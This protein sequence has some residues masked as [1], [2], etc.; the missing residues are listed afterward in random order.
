FL[1]LAVTLPAKGTEVS[2]H[3]I[4]S[5]IKTIILGALGDCARDTIVNRSIEAIN[6]S[7]PYTCFD[8]KL[9]SIILFKI[10]IFIYF[11]LWNRE[12]NLI[13]LSIMSSLSSFTD[14]STFYY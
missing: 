8:V 12:K 4:S 14:K 9:I 5:T 11:F 7:L 13:M 3:P 1:L 6:N 2:S 10:W